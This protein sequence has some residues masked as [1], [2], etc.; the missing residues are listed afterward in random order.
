M[1]ALNRPAVLGADE[2]NRDAML[3]KRDLDKSDFERLRV[4]PSFARIYVDLFFF[5]KLYESQRDVDK[6]Y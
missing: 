1:F 4:A 5:Q 6:K 3:F 2:I